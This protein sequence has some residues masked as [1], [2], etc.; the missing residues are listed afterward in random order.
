MLKPDSCKGCSMY[1]DGTGFVPDTIIPGSKVLIKG[2]NPG[3]DEECGHLITGYS[4]SRP[5]YEGTTPRPFIG[6]TGYTL[7]KTFLPLAGLNRKDISVSNTLRCRWHNSNDLPTG[8]I[9]K[10]AIVTCSQYDK[11]PPSIKVIVA[12]GSVAWSALRGPG[13]ITDWRGS[14]YYP[15]GISPPIYATVHLADLFRDS[16][17]DV[18]TRRD[19]VKLRKFLAG[20]WPRPLPRVVTPYDDLKGWL[21]DALN[22][23]FIAID[24]EYDPATKRLSLFGAGGLGIPT[25]Q[26]NT[27]DPFHKVAAK[28]L[29]TQILQAK[30]VVYQNALADIP[31]LRHNWGLSWEHHRRI[32]DSM[33]AHA[34]LWSELPHDLGFLASLYGGRSAYK[35]LSQEEPLYYHQCDVAET[36]EVWAALRVEL[37]GDKESQKVYNTQ[38]KLLPYIDES[39][40]R[41]IAVDQVKIGDALY[42][43]TQRIEQA[44][45]LGSAALG[46]PINMASSAQLQYQLYDIEGLPKQKHPKTKQAS[47]A[48]DAVAVLRGKYLEFDPQEEDDLLSE[49]YILGRIERG[50]HPLMEAMVL[51]GESRKCVSNYLK[52]LVSPMAVTRV[53]HS[54]KLHAQ[55]N[56]RWSY[57]D[58][59]LAQIPKYLLTIYKPDPGWPWLIF[60]M[61]QIELR[62][63]AMEC[64]DVT[65]LEAFANGWDI[66]SLSAYSMFDLPFPPDLTDPSHS[67]ANE[68]WR[69]LVKWLPCDHAHEVCGKDDPRRHFAKQFSHRA[70][71]GGTAK[72]AGDIPGAK[73]LGLDSKRL[74]EMARKRSTLLS[75]LTT[76]QETTARRGAELGM[77][78]TWY[79]R[80]RCY[81]G[82]R[83]VYLKGQIL[84]HPMQAGVVDLMM[85]IFLEIKEALGNDV[86]YV[87]GKHDSQ[88]WAIRAGVW[89]YAVN[90]IKSIVATP[91]EINGKVA[92]FPASFKER[93]K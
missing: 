90:T 63:V 48:K 79:G 18:V 81:L 4:G 75:G 14:L 25:L 26:L 33:Q 21:K 54:I 70:S 69:Q 40:S 27:G 58:P 11:V 22:L 59:P 6:P 65:L 1:Q 15:S 13:S 68:E 88:V 89:E 24:T 61:D 3:A 39:T 60:D 7:D 37:N 12:M 42:E 49:S 23:P 36:T 87:Y 73:A 45:Q 91:R 34:I 93:L 30:S 83:G 38:M 5:V 62:L 50:A 57:T 2:Q 52:P 77:T 35:H 29:V 84:D 47:I 46:W 19:Y 85:L 16:R 86:Y 10:E 55:A 67:P 17:M 71:Y 53:H 41:G 51:G 92:I 80:R 64:R 56:G 8:A 82:R 72:K 28:G 74:T 20:E 44:D 43:Y 76:W 31:I 66:H 32:E 78:R 9:L